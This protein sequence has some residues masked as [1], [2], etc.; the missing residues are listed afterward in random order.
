MVS[1]TRGFALA[2]VSSLVLAASDARADGMQGSLKD[3]PAPETYAWSGLSVGA[4]IGIGSFSQD[5]WADASRKD[6]LEKKHCWFSWWFKK[7]KCYKDFDVAYREQHGHFSEDSWKAFGTLQIGYDRL[8]R[9]RFLL[10]AF[11]D[12]D[13]YLD[14]KDDFSKDSVHYHKTIGTLSGDIER[15]HIWTVGGRFGVLL[16]PRVL[17]YALAGYS[18]MKLDGSLNVHFNDPFYYTNAP[19]DLTLKLPS[20]LHGWTVGAGVEL[21][22]EKRLSLKLEYRYSH[23]DGAEASASESTFEKFKYYGY[24]SKTEV[25]HWIK[26]NANVALSDTDVHSV[27]AVLVWK[28]TDDARHVEPLK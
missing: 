1:R 5:I 3:S 23:F 10:G 21:K 18:Q 16:R 12:L 24:D 4:G 7:W 11:A 8:I 19:S 2:V 28:L 13:F 22:R 17:A 9:D 25:K 26:E 15:E 6:L 27:R 14:A 20:E